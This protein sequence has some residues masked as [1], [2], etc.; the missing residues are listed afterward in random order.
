MRRSLR[1]DG[2][3]NDV[4]LAIHC[5]DDLR[6]ASIVA[7]NLAQAADSNIDTTVKRIGFPAPQ[8]LSELRPAEHAIRR[9]QQNSQEPILRAA[10]CN[11]F[12]VGV[13]QRAGRGIQ[14]PVAEVNDRTDSGLGS[15]GAC[16]ALRNTAL[17]RPSNSRGLKGFGT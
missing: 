12:A 2:D 15:L 9:R 4:S 7:E 13:C 10:Q 8:Q 5:F 11:V 16:A 14:L 6:R 3:P 17:I 1:L